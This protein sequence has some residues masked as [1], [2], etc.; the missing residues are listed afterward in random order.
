MGPS[1]CGGELYSTKLKRATL[2]GRRHNERE[3]TWVPNTMEPR[4]SLGLF[5]IR[6]LRKRE[7]NFYPVSPTV[8]L[9]SIK[10]AKLIFYC[11]FTLCS[12]SLKNSNTYV[13]KLYLKIHFMFNIFQCSPIILKC[14]NIP[15]STNTLF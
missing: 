12:F 10:A 4:I 9:V 15:P 14:L 6:L 13:L 8:N 3:E 7:I 11:Y 1:G 2:K 5:V